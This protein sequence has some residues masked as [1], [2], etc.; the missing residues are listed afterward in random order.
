LK[1]DFILFGGTGEQG[2]ICAR[3]ILESGCSVLLVGRNKSRV[4]KLLKNKKAGFMRVD[5]REQNKIE[6]AIKK[7]QADVVIN[8]AELVFN[9]P[10]MKACL[11]NKKSI[12]DLGGL[13]YITLE[14]FKLHDDF[15]KAGITNITGCGSTPGIVNVMAAHVIEDFDS[16]D[17]ITLGFV[18]D[19]NIKKFVVPYS[20]HSIFDEFTQAPVTL[21]NGKFVK[22]NRFKCQGTFNFKEVGK[23]TVY[24]IV[25]SEVYTFSKYFKDKGLKNIHYMAGFPEH[26][27]KVI[28]TLMDLGFSSDRE[29]EASGTKIKPVNFTDRVL[30]KLKIPKG[31]KEVENL[32]VKISGMKSGKKKESKIDC[33]IKSLPGW[34]EAA[35]NVDTG[36]TISIMSQMLRNGEVNKHGVFAPEEVIPHNHFIKELGERKMHVYVD[37]KKIN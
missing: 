8:C 14:Q 36:R 2:R 30:E 7:S 9:V 3:D 28:K 4:Q 11:K 15:K 29:I 34:E 5:L 35:S 10:I 27:I 1:Y 18:W 25:H 20:I 22:E 16:V 17:T 6:E 37:G 23:Q 31:Y 32:W 19:S 26:S 24:C 12:T 13:Q 21:H 33:I